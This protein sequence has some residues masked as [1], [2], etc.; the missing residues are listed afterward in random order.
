MIDTAVLR[1]N[2][3]NL[4]TSGQL[5]SFRDT[6]GSVEDI[7]KKL[8]EPSIK[9]KKYLQQE[10]E[11]DKTF[12]IPPHWKWVKLGEVCSYGD[13]P[14]KVMIS[15]CN[16]DTWVLELEDIQAGGRLLRKKR[17]EEKKSIGEKTK[18]KEG[19][20]LYSKL[21]PYLKKVLVADENGISTPELIASDVYAG[22]NPQYLVYC[23]TNSYV[24]RVINKRSYGI[25][26]PRV[27]AG[28][29]VNLPIPLPPLE[30]QERI[31]N[32]VENAIQ[33]IVQID[34]W[35][36]KYANNVQILQSKIIDAGIQGKLTEQLPEDG[37][38]DE[39]YANIQEEKKKVIE[40]G[41]LKGRKN[42]KV[43]TIDNSEGLFE[44][45]SNWKW[46]R[47]GEVCEIFGRIGFRGYT[48]ADIVE[49]HEGAITI[50]PSNIDGNGNMHFDECTYLSWFKYEESPEIQIE[51]EDIIIVKTGSSYGKAGIV[52]NLPEKATINPQL[53]VLKYVCC[54][55]DYLNYVLNC[56]SS[57]RQYE[58]FVI[59][60]AIPTFSQEKLANLL[61]PLPPLSEQKRIVERIEGILSII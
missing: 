6:D 25:K 35:Q 1:I 34:V 48:K 51:N 17:V 5:T 40:S 8:P 32:I 30:E 50:S 21:R 20:L 23:L 45:P 27:D 3:L 52:K 13:T 7:I 44:I 56:S 47:L 24:D 18:F 2:I 29:M 57:K 60:A 41:V 16:D 19:Q 9:R 55:R 15:E 38:A 61:I 12:E 22:I 37:T 39:L 53:A 58:Q 42:K 43:D 54:N 33:E 31:V 59:G 4:A 49:P 10:F 14:T 11:Y 28:F 46:I 36:E 26:M